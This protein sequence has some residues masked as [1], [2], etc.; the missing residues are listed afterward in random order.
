MIV[1][2]GLVLGLSSC[3]AP[4]AVP[5]EVA[6][7]PP[8]VPGKG[9]PRPLAGELS[10]AEPTRVLIPRLHVS[11]PLVVLGVGDDGAL[12]VPPLDHGNVAG[13]YGGGVTPG[14]RGSA[15]IAGHLDTRRGPA[16]FARLA[17][18]RAGDVVGVVRADTSV[19]VFVVERLS[20]A[21]K[22]R[23]PAEE[24]YGPADTRW[25][26]LVTCGGSF[27]RVRRTY[28][29]NVI[30]HARFRAAYASADLR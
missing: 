12:A 8:A 1:A 7:G 6:G 10:R 21:P 16:V 22:D 11:A 13:W 23:F 14:E 17:E 30:V 15:V 4:P 5:W 9:W 2:V 28:S 19:A 29:D 3:T 26:R 27:D 24:V 20:R 25:L 18:L